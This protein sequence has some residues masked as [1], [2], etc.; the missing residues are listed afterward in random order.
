MSEGPNV[1]TTDEDMVPTIG[2]NAGP[3]TNIGSVGDRN[4]KRTIY[5]GH[6]GTTLHNRMTEHYKAVGQRGLQ[7]GIAKHHVALHLG[8]GTTYWSS[9]I[10]DVQTKNLN[11][12]ASE[13]LCILRNGT[14]CNLI[15]SKGEFDKMNLPRLALMDH[16][17]D[18][19][20]Q[21][22]DQDQ[23]GPHLNG[24][25]RQWDPG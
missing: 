12:M 5:I 10:L 21:D 6:S 7:S 17:T 23:N 11:R 3:G 14:T 8:H 20:D 24:P 2:T 25:Y 13:A 19:R 1:S 9:K 4:K 16:P 18:V 15:N 22:M